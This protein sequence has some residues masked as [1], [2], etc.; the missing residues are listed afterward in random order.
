MV[1]WRSKLVYQTGPKYRKTNLSERKPK[2][3]LIRYREV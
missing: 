1:G 3:K 2:E